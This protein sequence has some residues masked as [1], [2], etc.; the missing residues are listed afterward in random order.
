[1]V[2]LEIN[3]RHLDNVYFVKDSICLEIE[4]W[5]LRV[6]ETKAKELAERAGLEHLLN[7]LELVLIHHGK[8]LKKDDDIKPIKPGST[9]HILLKPVK[10]PEIPRILNR[11]E[12]GQLVFAIRTAVLGSKFRSGL[13]KIGAPEN[14]E[15]LFAATPGLREDPIA[16]AFLHDH[17]LLF[18]FSNPEVA[19]KIA[20]KCPALADA[21]TQI[22][23]GSLMPNEGA[24][25]FLDPE[26]L[27]SL[28][29]TQRDDDDT[30]EDEMMLDTEMNIRPSNTSRQRSI[31][32][33]PRGPPEQG[34]ITPSYLAAA[35][36]SARNQ[37]NS[38]PSTSQGTSRSS[39]SVALA[40]PVVT[41]EMMQDAI[42]AAFSGSQTRTP[43]PVRRPAENSGGRTPVATLRERYRQEL[44]QMQ[45]LGLFNEELVLRALDATSGDVTAAAN[46]IF[47]GMMD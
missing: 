32:P 40:P 19:K 4:D 26:M 46:L 41:P 18:Q 33:G 44:S 31:T 11:A 45:E 43:S 25:N 6:I 7:E 13:Q 8:I 38:Q 17:E 5:N 22:A 30:D 29:E 47:A 14:I 2:T 12:I 34:G 36:W 23:G 9:I 28:R 21:A 3:H 27:M 10:E 24:S 42:R 37:P 35:L 1:M 20:E 15:R 16:L 39:S